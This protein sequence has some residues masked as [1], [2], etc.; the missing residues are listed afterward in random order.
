MEYDFNQLS[1]VDF[2]KLVNAILV[3]ELGSLIRIT[4][5]RGRDG[6]RDAEIPAD[7]PVYGFTLTRRAH[8]KQ[9]MAGRYVFQ[10]KHHLTTDRRGTDLRKEIIAEFREE[11]QANVLPNKGGNRANYFFLITNVP[12]SRESVVAVD[13]ARKELLKDTGIHADVWWKD[14]LSAMLDGHP[15]VWSSYPEVLPGRIVPVLAQLTSRNQPT[16]STN[17][18][19]RALSIQYE[20][21]RSVRFRQIRLE[22]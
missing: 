21:D 12:S 7:H 16:P 4:P 20:R 8:S 5:V 10:V 15:E 9:W 19:H 3:K 14:G 2:Q 6:G 22:S 18:L 11:L 13:T 1:P 17:T